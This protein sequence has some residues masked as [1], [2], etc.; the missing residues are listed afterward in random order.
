MAGLMNV[1][2]YNFF[3]P[4]EGLEFNAKSLSLKCGGCTLL[5][6]S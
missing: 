1:V 6:P 2:L 3:F 5:Y 4:V